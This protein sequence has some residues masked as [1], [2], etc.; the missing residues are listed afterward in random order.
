[1]LDA[2]DK[3]HRDFL[4]VFVRILRIEKSL[5][6]ILI[7]TGMSRDGRLESLVGS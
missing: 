7:T 4:K 2:I 3:S 5:E 6:M 1:M